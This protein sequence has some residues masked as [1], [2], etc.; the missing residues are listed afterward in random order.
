MVEITQVRTR[1]LELLRKLPRVYRA[2]AEE[3][4]TP[5]ALLEMEDPTSDWGGLPAED[6]TDAFGRM[7]RAG[8]IV[9]RNQPAIGQRATLVGDLLDG[10]HEMPDGGE[11]GMA[12]GRAVLLTFAERRLRATKYGQ[13]SNTRAMFMSDDETVGTMQRPWSDQPGLRMQDY[14]PALPL[15]RLI[16]N[17]TQ[18]TG[19]SY[20][21]AYVDDIRPADDYTYVRIAEG[22][23]IPTVKLR[24]RAAD[25]RLHKYGIAIDWTYEAEREM[26][27]DKLGLTLTKIELSQE[28]AKVAHVLSV[29]LNGLAGL[30]LTA[31]PTVNL[32]TYAPA[33]AGQLD[34]KSW[35]R[36]KRSL[37]K[38]Y[39]PDVL[40]GD[41]AAIAQFEMMPIAVG[42][43][44]PLLTIS[45]SAGIGTIQ[46]ISSAGAGNNLQYEATTAMPAG[47]LLL[48]DTR[49]LIE[50]VSQIGA[51]VNEADSFITNQ[52]RIMTFTE[53]ENY[54]KMFESASIVLNLTA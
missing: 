18:I 6:R 3:G 41:D 25:L 39:V 23:E 1:P 29:I 13:T 44:M 22:A 48:M 35:L 12:N 38:T 32:S 8:G 45:G 26:T 43:N 24:T 15:S 16:A 54:T 37:P 14:R 34:L 4:V 28:D 46:P 49:F 5:S 19:T 9:P 53:T 36:F 42:T 21:A 47:K 7:C 50:R 51:M 11:I 52:T 2:A 40:L 17:E 20:R 31:S 27:L 33:T 30:P 10:I